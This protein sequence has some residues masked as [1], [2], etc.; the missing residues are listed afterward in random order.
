MTGLVLYDHF[1]D[2]REDMAGSRWNAFVESAIAARPVR[3]G[4]PAPADVEAVMLTRPVVTSFFALID[5]ELRAGEQLAAS[6][7]VVNL[8][9]H[10]HGLAVSSAMRANPSRLVMPLLANEPIS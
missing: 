2:W 5:R 4:A 9:L 1:V 7:G 3:P 6:V 10:L 8:A